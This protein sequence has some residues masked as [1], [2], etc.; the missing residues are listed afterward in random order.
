VFA[1]TEILSHLRRGV[2]VGEIV[3]G[4]LVSVVT[5]VVEMDPLEGEVVLTGGVAAHNPT[6]AEILA[7]R[8]GR[9]VT[10]PPHPQFTGALGAALTALQG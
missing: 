8:L 6:I 7:E 1:K 4:A 3:R 2:P 9:P 10:V 5:R